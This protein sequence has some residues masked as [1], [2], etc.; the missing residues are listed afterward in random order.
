MCIGG[1]IITVSRLTLEQ[2]CGKG[3][4]LKGIQLSPVVAKAAEYP[5]AEIESAETW[6]RPSRSCLKEGLL[7]PAKRYS[8][9]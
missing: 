6:R 7:Y 2:F 9:S 1:K 8:A 3:K 4:K 5:S